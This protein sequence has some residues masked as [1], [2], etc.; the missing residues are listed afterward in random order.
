MTVNSQTF[1]TSTRNDDT[2]QDVRKEMPDPDALLDIADLL[3]SSFSNNKS[4][5]NDNN[6]NSSS[7]NDE[8]NNN[9]FAHSYLPLG[10]NGKLQPIARVGKLGDDAMIMKEGRAND[11]RA[12]HDGIP[13]A[14]G[15][16]Q[17]EAEEAAGAG[18]AGVR[19]GAPRETGDGGGSRGGGTGGVGVELVAVLDPLSVAAQRAS[20]LLLV[21]SQCVVAVVCLLRV[22]LLV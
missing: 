10:G 12:D 19:G 2:C 21:V 17:G 9:P 3:S 14:V 6:S 8:Y 4:E 13:G 22:F 18:G 11:D 1:I 20:T 7:N 16:S 15:E 5:D